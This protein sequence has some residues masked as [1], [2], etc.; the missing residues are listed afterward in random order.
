M[1]NTIPSLDQQNLPPS[2][3]NRF[4][5]E[6]A[7]RRIEQL[8][9]ENWTDYNSHDPGITI[10]ELLA[11]AI[12][13]L[14]LR[15]NLEISDLIARGEDKPFFTAR[16]V[17][18]NAAYA[19]IDYRCLLIDRPKVRNAYVEKT[20][21]SKK[22]LYDVLLDLEPEVTINQGEPQE[23]QEVWLRGTPIQI[24]ANTYEFY[25][26]FPYWENLPAVWSG[27]LDLSQVDIS[28]VQRADDP[29][30][31]S[32]D[33]FFTEPTFIF[34]QGNE[35]ETLD[36]MG[37]LIRLPHGVPKSDTN[38]Q[39][40]DAFE[41]ALISQLHE[42]TA[43][44]QLHQ[45]SVRLRAERLIL[46]KAFVLQHRNLC[47]DWQNIDTIRIQQIGLLIQELELQPDANPEEVVAQVYFEIDQFLDPQIQ[48][49][50]F[51]SLL[52]AG[53]TADEIFDGPLLQNGFLLKE[54]LQALERD[55]KIY[56][57][58][59][60]RI[61]MQLPEVIGVKQLT[62]DQYLDRIRVTSGVVN[63]LQL[64][65][66]RLYKP[67]FSFHDSTI[68]VVKRGV[69]IELDLTL[70][71][72]LWLAKKEAFSALLIADQSGDLSIP[73]GDDDLDIASFYSIQNEFP[74]TYGL[75]EGEIASSATPLRKA[76]AKQLK[77]YLLFFEQLLNNYCEQLANIQALF[78]MQKNTG[79]TYFFQPLYDVPAVQ[80]LYLAFIDEQSINP[81]ISWEAFKSNCNAYIKA[82][83]FATEERSTFLKRRNQFIN[84]LLAR[85]A[86]NFTD[87]A[88]WV[89]VQHGGQV[90]PDLLFDKLDFLQQFP[91][92]SS[93]R[94]TAFDYTATRND[95]N[96]NEIPDVWDTE[97]V[98]GYEKRVAALLGIPDIRR[99][100]LT[101]VFDIANYTKDEGDHFD[102]WNGPVAQVV[103]DPNPFKILLTSRNPLTAQ[104][105]SKVAGLARNAKNYKVFQVTDTRLDTCRYYFNLLENNTPVAGLLEFPDNRAEPEDAIREVI[106]LVQGRYTEGMHLVEHILLRP[107]EGQTEVLEPIVFPLD[108][109]GVENG[110]RAVTLIA[111]T[112]SFQVSIFL[113]GWTPRFSDPEFR[114]VAER[115]LREEL[116]A[117]IFPWIFWVELT[118]GDEVP[119]EYLEFE[120]AYQTW[121]ESLN[122]PDRDSAQNELIIRMNQLVRSEQTIPTHSYKP[123]DLQS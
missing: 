114:V 36:D 50:S 61:I 41:A 118:E 17:L 53:K 6:E 26:V 40:V 31:S 57:S 38:T 69:A 11:Y 60:I 18:P 3:N 52:A 113:P 76:Q 51:E 14:G 59:L 74:Q 81:P 103:V 67:K 24:G 83:D 90:S 39:E 44:F 45:T 91:E 66:A 35:A 22:G 71:K 121:L 28:S 77:A 15:T 92:L 49:Q 94:A 9:S 33:L 27:E 12:T 21:G 47:E 104:E 73:E 95:G 56:T 43:F 42:N 106:H 102:F 120:L 20:P 115:K 58:D 2:L 89:F 88:A 8:A 70:I 23:L 78:S 82:L 109:N 16:E 117:H 119:P 99:R 108:D 101:E 19:P 110:P 62:L 32:F 85:F 48:P 25:I 75:K 122:T 10:L 80:S 68:K 111:D 112:Y 37:L 7:R 100:S 55:D 13:D 4:L 93:N 98:S 63:C 116:P 79:R 65:N 29:N 1:I 107:I 54:S 46:E 96:D 64:R 105:L 5:K 84:H 30:K 86:E 72:Q 87:Y 97:N 123:F 34:G